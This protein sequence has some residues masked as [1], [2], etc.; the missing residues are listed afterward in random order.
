MPEEICCQLLFSDKNFWRILLISRLW[1]ITVFSYWWKQNQITTK[2]VKGIKVIKSSIS[3]TGQLW[4]QT[5]LDDVDLFHIL[6]K[7][8]YIMFKLIEILEELWGYLLLL[9]RKVNTCHIRD[10]IRMLQEFMSE[11]K[12]FLL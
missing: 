11:K 1:T 6:K 5:L 10:I 3:I 9:I 4:V 12:S 7:Y 8:R 2:W